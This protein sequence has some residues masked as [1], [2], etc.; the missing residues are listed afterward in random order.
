M[1]EASSQKK[2]DT[3]RRRAATLNKFLYGDHLGA[4]RS[5]LY[6]CCCSIEIPNFTD[7]L[8]IPRAQN[9][10]LAGEQIHHSILTSRLECHAS[11]FDIHE[12][13]NF[14]NADAASPFLC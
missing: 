9:A 11:H 2:A 12:G 10:T 5:N 14:L 8:E 1:E 4:T 6:L 3:R 7:S 13:F